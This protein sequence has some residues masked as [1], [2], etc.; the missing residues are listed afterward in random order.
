MW[1][2]GKLG[3]LSEATGRAIAFCKKLQARS[4]SSFFHVVFVYKLEMCSRFYRLFLYV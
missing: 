2:L 3:A 1:N 4:P